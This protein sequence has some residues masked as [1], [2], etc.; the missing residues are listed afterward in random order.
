MEAVHYEKKVPRGDWI[1]YMLN[2]RIGTLV[3]SASVSL[4]GIVVYSPNPWQELTTIIFGCQ[5]IKTSLRYLDCVQATTAN[6]DLVQ[7]LAPLQALSMTHQFT[8]KKGY[9]WIHRIH[10]DTFGFIWRSQDTYA[11]I[12]M[13]LGT[14]G[15]FGYIRYN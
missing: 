1:Q 12:W 10:L 6:Y 14:F 15:Y 3:P 13:N 2:L 9:I 8:R 11:Y 4:S 5:I 7:Y